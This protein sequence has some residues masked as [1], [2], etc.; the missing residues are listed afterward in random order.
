MYTVLWS[1]KVIFELFQVTIAHLEVYM[2]MIHRSTVLST[3][4]V[5][6]VPAR[7]HRVR[8]TQRYVRRRLKGHFKR[9]GFTVKFL[10][11]RTLEM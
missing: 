1:L 2:P 5:Q 3:I 7:R 11:F 9:A 10:N 6:K 4:S 8:I